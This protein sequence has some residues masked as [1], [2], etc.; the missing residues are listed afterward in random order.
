MKI[1][2]TCLLTVAMLMPSTSMVVATESLCTVEVNV[3]WIKLIEN[4]GIGNDWSFQTD[5]RGTMQRV[6]EYGS[7]KPIASAIRPV[8]T[9]ISLNL[10]AIEDDKLDDVGVIEASMPVTCEPT[11]TTISSHS[12]DVEV[13]ETHGPGAGKTATWQF[14]LEV[15]SFIDSKSSMLQQ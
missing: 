10:Y 14:K 4:N 5:F 8:G 7:L 11:T 6:R 12:F 9:M 2:V 3:K 1:L 13:L 15:T